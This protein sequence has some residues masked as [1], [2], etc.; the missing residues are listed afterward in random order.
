[1]IRAPRLAPGAPIRVVAPSG[2]VP[3]EA[4][5]AGLAVLRARYDVRWDE[6]TVLAR[7]GFLAGP[8]EQ[9]L[10]ALVDA[11][12]EPDVAAVIMARGG[13][14]LLR[15][16]PFLDPAL[17]VRSPR[18]LVG[19]SDG[20][21]LLAVAAGAGVAAIHGPVVTQLPSLSSDDHAALFDRLERPGPAV[22]LDGLEEVV[23]GR[24]RGPLIGGNL[25]VFS[26][27]LGTPF[28]PDLG[29]AILFFEDLGE[30]PYRI[31]RLITHLDLAGV[32][33]VAA[34]VVLGDFSSCREP[35]PTRAGTPTADEVLVERLGRLS[36]PVASGGAFG[37]GT[38]NR[39]LVTGA[40]AE[41]DTRSGTLVTLEGAVA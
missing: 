27:L 36:I 8:D 1:M 20:T 4:F 31:D 19:F 32:F 14:G 11:L 38:R 40:L 30:R 35:E 29:G 7:T 22:L 13:Y 26:R 21:A 16:L 28:L 18:P 24:V 41:L 10:A 6:P 15:L 17:L 23:P 33:S 2:P 12:A 37:H 5:A 3:P 39:P 25:E 34:G 9:R